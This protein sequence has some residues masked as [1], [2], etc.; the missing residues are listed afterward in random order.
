MKKNVFFI[1]LFSFS[2]NLLSAQFSH[3]IGASYFIAKDKAGENG[4]GPA[5]TYFPKYSIGSLS[6]GVPIS[7]GITGSANSRTGASEGSSLTLQL[8]IVV[9]YNIGLGAN[10]DE[11]SESGFGFYVGA[12]FG[13][14][15]TSYVGAFTSGTLKATGPLARAGAR[16]NVKEKLIDLGASYHL[17]LDDNKVGAIGITAIYNF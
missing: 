17:G 10:P 12:G 3:G 1:I 2:A 4:G 11:E 9:D 15:S 5:V 16:F 8:P 13:V 6:V 7:L 14:F